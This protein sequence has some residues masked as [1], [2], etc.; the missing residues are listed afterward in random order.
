MLPAAVQ[1]ERFGKYASAVARHEAA[2]G[3]PAPDPTELGRNGKPRL[4]PGFPEWM[5][6]LP[7]GHL[8]DVVERS[9]A[10]KLAGNGVNW[11]QCAYALPLLPTFRAAVRELT[12]ARL[13]LAA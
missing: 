3:L 5:Q 7:R 13:E 1:P 2:Y 6:G 8:T 11:R 4:A 10:L 9:A 12:A